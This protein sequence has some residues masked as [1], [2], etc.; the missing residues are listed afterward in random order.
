M[1]RKGENIYK[2]K[3]SRW[4]A[5]ILIGHDTSGK[6]I[7]KSVYACS[8]TEVKYK[9]NVFLKNLCE[10]ALT[11]ID[12]RELQFTEWL[13][14]KKCFVKASTFEKYESITRLYLMPFFGNMKC[15]DITARLV[16]DFVYKMLDS[17]LSESTIQTA[18]CVLKEVLSKNEIRIDL[19]QVEIPSSKVRTEV[20]DRDS[21]SVLTSF[22]LD[23]T[24]KIKLGVLI[25]L[26]TGMRIGELCALK[27]GDVS[28]ESIKI[29]KSLQRLSSDGNDSKTAIII[30]DP[31]S[32]SSVR[33]IPIPCFLISTINNLRED[34]DKYILT[35]NTKPTEPRALRKR[36]DTM[37]KKCGIA[38][39]NF[40]ALRHTFATRCIES[41]VDV[42]TLSEILGHSSVRI[43]LD[44]YVHVSFEQKYA[45]INKLI[46]VY[47]PSNLQS[48]E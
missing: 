45:N 13:S 29:T 22:L 37:L 36:Y 39:I 15:N 5:R 35:G 32:I 34:N 24:D 3:D 44:R 4:E 40:H 30:S 10:Q 28:S 20:L 7:Y 14:A 16:Q 41:G 48:Q 25:C 43:T 27:W 8:Y 47:S 6:A 2:R 26:Y 19:S 31:K 33:T 38:H 23:K 18:L 17:G 11:N 42:K 9:R 21:Q 1:P 46:S 12:E